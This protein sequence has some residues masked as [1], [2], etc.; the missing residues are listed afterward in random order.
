MALRAP[1]LKDPHIVVRLA[2]NPS[3]ITEANKLVCANYIEEGYWDN[4]APFR[5]NR[6]MHVATR[7]VFVAD[8]KDRIVGTASIVKDSRDGLPLEKAFPEAVKNFRNRGERLAEVSALAVDKN[9][10]EQRTLV[11]FL[12]KYLVQYSFYYAHIDRFVIAI[13]ARHAPFYKSV[14]CF[15]ELSG[16]GSYDYVKPEFKPV[17]LT[18]PLLKA[19]KMWYDRYEVGMADARNSFYRFMFVDEHPS[20]RFPDKKLMSRRREIDWVAEAQLE[21][22]PMAG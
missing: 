19:H 18:L 21:Q 13:V 1:R 17:L 3:E 4:D 2:R 8:N 5:Q 11:L 20:L 6:H 9:S 15:E 10:A 14:Y 7:V 22:L 16:G 12:F